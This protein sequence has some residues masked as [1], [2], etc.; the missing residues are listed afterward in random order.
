MYKIG[1]TVEARIPVPCWK[2]KEMVVKGKI[3]SI[4]GGAKRKFYTITDGEV[5]RDFIVY[6]ISRPQDFPMNP[7]K[8]T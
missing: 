2:G 7:K 1:D 4:R 5:Q 8:L 6:K 3:K